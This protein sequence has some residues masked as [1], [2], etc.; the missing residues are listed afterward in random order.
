MRFAILTALLGA[1]DVM[2]CNH[3]GK[4]GE[5]KKGTRLIS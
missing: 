5:G 4:M 1:T 3:E 2:S